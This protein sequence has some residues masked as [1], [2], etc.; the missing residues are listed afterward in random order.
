MQ[1]V[2]SRP[3]KSESSIKPSLPPEVGSRVG[4][5]RA[6]VEFCAL[7]VGHNI[8]FAVSMLPALTL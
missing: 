8:H 4:G 2:G 3:L 1:G 5:S 6:L 7:L